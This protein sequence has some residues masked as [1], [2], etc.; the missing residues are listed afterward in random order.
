MLNILDS[1]NTGVTY[2]HIPSKKKYT[3]IYIE[4]FF[5]K[6]WIIRRCKKKILLTNNIY[7][8]FQFLSSRCIG[9]MVKLF[10]QVCVPWFES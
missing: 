9:Q 8:A 2:T 4:F 6:A 7:F 1:F 5:T 10:N 3:H